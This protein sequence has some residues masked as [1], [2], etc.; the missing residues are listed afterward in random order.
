MIL[1]WYGM[2]MVCLPSLPGSKN[3]VTRG[4]GLSNKS[5][6]LFYLWRMYISQVN[7]N[8]LTIYRDLRLPSQQKCSNRIESTSRV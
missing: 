5:M 6:R 3:I 8:V 2:R 1:V 4:E 7:E